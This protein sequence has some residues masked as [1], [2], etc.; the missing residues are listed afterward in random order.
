MIFFY[1]CIYIYTVYTKIKH[2]HHLTAALFNGFHSL[3]MV[4]G[5]LH[6]CAIDIDP[7]GN[8]CNV[9]F[10]VTQAVFINTDL[11]AKGQITKFTLKAFT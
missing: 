5:Y 6:S 4:N 7:V 11:T 2:S 9:E 3:N 1:S 10:Y 8:Y